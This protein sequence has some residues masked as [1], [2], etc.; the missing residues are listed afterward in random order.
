MKKYKAVIIDD[1]AWTR[2]VIRNLGA[3]EDYGIEIAGE[4]SDGEYGLELI[5]Q[6]HPDIILTDVCMPQMNGLELIEKLRQSRPDVQVIFISGYDDY[7]YVRSAM[8]L[9]AVDYLLKPVKQEELNRQ[10]QVCLEKLRKLERKQDQEEL[11]ADFLKESWADEFDNLRSGI[12]EA[13]NFG[14]TADVQEKLC[15]LKQLLSVN[16]IDQPNKSSMISIYFILINQLRRYIQSRDYKPEEI[17]GQKNTTFV[18]SGDSQP[19]E[20]MD[21]IIDLHLNALNRVHELM[22]SRHRLD[23]SQVCKYLEENYTQGITL[24]QTAGRFYISKEYLS[25]TF[26]STTGKGFSEYITALRMEK[27]KELLIKYRV[28][29]REVG[30]MV[31][32]VDQAHFY[33]TFKKYFGRTPGEIAG[34][35]F[36]NK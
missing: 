15:E 28:P 11:S 33:K 9:N 23:I 20:M 1:E 26:K 7:S 30:E 3:F 2:K 5:R 8:K 12:N 10:L 13:L 18:F 25:K 14:S 17:F 21:F 19:S 4:A 24:E 6:V 16:M 22:K 27:A 35:K 32:Y 36:D 31:G 34:L 29:I